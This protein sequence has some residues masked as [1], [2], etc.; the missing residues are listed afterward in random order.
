MAQVISLDNRQ[1]YVEISHVN[2]NV[3]VNVPS[4]LQNLNYGVPQGSILGPLLFICYVKGLPNVLED[5]KVC[6]YADDI[7]LLISGNTHQKVEEIAYAELSGINT[8]LSN[9]NLLVNTN[10]TKYISFTTHQNI[11][12]VQPN[13]FLGENSLD[14]VQNS[15]FLGLTLDKHFKWNLHIDKLCRTISSGMFALRKMSKL[16]SI[17][18]LKTIYF[19]F[20][21]SHISFGIIL[22]GATSHENLNKLLVLQKQA[23]RIMLGLKRTDSVKELFSRLGIFT[24]FGQYIFE[25]ILFVRKNLPKFKT[26]GSCHN[27][28]TRNRKKITFMN[29]NLKF[30]EKKPSYAGIRYYNLLPEKIVNIT[31]EKKFKRELKN[32]MLLKPVYSLSEF[33]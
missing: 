8:F 7:N 11:N 16:C 10:K 14:E 32:Y 20:I 24:V 29:H 19:A 33:V 3:K 30:L 2:N 9:L 21:H 28:N 25:L 5:A 13:I 26:L 1:Q 4:S 6:L 12:Q 22:Y 31:D 15:K 27:Y 23:L 17:E 18:T